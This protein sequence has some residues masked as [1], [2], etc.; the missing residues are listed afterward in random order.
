M[1]IKKDG[2]NLKK[3][4]AKEG[5]EIKQAGGAVFIEGFANKATVDRGNDLISPDAWDL[6]NFKKNPII[7]F[8]HGMDSLGGTPVGRATQVKATEE[9]LYLKVRLS[10]SEAPGIKMVR[11]LVQEKILQAFSVGFEPKETEIKTVGEGENAQEVNH[12][13][14]AELFETSIVGIPMNQDSLFT[15]SEK[16]LTT[17]SLYEV[18]KD[19]LSQKGADYASEVHEKIHAL[20]EAGQDR[21]EIL[22][23]LAEA[24]N[25]PID[26]VKDILAG[27]SEPTEDFKQAVES[28]LKFGDDDEDKED[29]EEDDKEKAKESE[30]S[31]EDT[32]DED[33]GAGEKEEKGAG[34]EEGEDTEEGD[35]SDE[36]KDFQ[37]CVAGKVPTLI[38]EG[39][40]QDQ[41]VAAAISACQEE[42]KC[43]LA[44]ESKAVAFAACFD[45]VE[46][47]TNTG[48]W[49]FETL[50]NADIVVTSTQKETKQAEQDGEN[51]TSV[52]IQT[53]KE[54]TD[55]GSPFLEQQ[56]Q[57]NI[58]LGTLISEIQ[59]LNA[60]IEGLGQKTELFSDDT[61]IKASEEDT[62][63]ED[64]KEE[65]VAKAEKSL[66]SLNKRLNNLGY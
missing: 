8:N 48:E 12:I 3:I 53:T 26:E 29:E 61:D 60:G 39:M 18:K 16:M 54:D 64:T 62:D 30:D 56:K 38:S 63:E 7:L 65:T 57:T 52:P 43:S 35:Q 2:K 6:D 17:K 10:N 66:A 45:A 51:S 46:K 13:T 47:F 21:L 31:K 1:D 36:R 40:E 59:K 49:D 24:S 25:L 50:S 19:V 23:L 22:S 37:D 11:D 34:E 42:G 15:V 9:G 4:A 20:E 33:E 27:N 5:F 32:E 41:A 28:V 14:K 55:F 58:M 44:P